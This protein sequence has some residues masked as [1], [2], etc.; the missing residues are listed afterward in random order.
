MPRPTTEPSL[1]A[2]LRQLAFPIAVVALTAGATHGFGAVTVTNIPVLGLSDTSNEGRAITTDAKYVVGLSGTGSGFIYDV[3]NN[4]VSQPDGGLPAAIATGVAYRTDTNQ[5]PAQLQLVV[6]GLSPSS[7]INYYTAWMTAD[8]GA[9]WNQP[10]QV[11]SGAFPTV[12]VANGLAGTSWDVLYTAWTDEG[13]NVGHDN[14]TLEVGQLSGTWITTSWSTKGATSPAQLQMN[15]ISSNGRAAG[16]RTNNTANTVR[17]LYVT[18]WEP[19]GAYSIWSPHGLDGTTAGQAYSVSADGTVIFGISPKGAATGTTNFGFKAT[20]NTTFPGNAGTQLTTNQL[21]NFADTA[22]SNTLAIPYGCTPDGTY[23]VGMSYRG[24]EKAVIWDTHDANP[25]NWTVFDLTALA[26]GNLDVFLRLT[27]AYSV[28]TNAAGALVITGIGR[29]TNS[30]PANT[31]AFLMTVP[32]SALV[33]ASV[34]HIT[35]ISF[36]GSNVVL[37][38]TSSSLADTTAS[39][40]VQHSATLVNGVNS[41]FADVSPAAAITGSAGSFQAT[42]AKSGNTQ[43]YRIHHP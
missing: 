9:S 29:D 13:P 24:T 34:I 3:A 33:A 23:A 1:S 31:R 28:G 22:G 39:F 19:G 15:T 43:F 38:F 30:S 14:W 8:G 42:F 27:R 6:S 4:T 32:K 18:D 26:S 21:P 10:Y 35:R 37:D 5:D 7:S 16:W 12:P 17:Y 11:V 36:N 20:F 40:T 41:S 2:R 25:A